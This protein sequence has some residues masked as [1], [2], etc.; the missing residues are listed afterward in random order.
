MNCFEAF[1]EL[2]L[3]SSTTI[4][5]Y[6]SS[7]SS[8]TKGTAIE[9][10]AAEIPKGRSFDEIIRCDA[11]CSRHRSPRH[12][13]QSGIRIYY[14]ALWRNSSEVYHVSL[15][16]PFSSSLSMTDD[17]GAGLLHSSVTVRPRL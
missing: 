4:S 14:R 16:M 15:H 6:E 11:I 12:G 3:C 13:H 1:G 2:H 8:H 9:M 5:T 7:E 10:N 17:W